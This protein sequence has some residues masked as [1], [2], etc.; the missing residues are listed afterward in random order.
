MRQCKV[1]INEV[2]AGLLQETDDRQYI[3]TSLVSL[4]STKACSAKA[5]N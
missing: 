5:C 1:F 4:R 3:F 2:E